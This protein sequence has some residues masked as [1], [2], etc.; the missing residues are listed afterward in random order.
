MLTNWLNFLCSFI[1]D[2]S[3]TASLVI[4]SLID[5]VFSMIKDG[6]FQISI[7]NVSTVI[8]IRFMVSTNCQVLEKSV[9]VFL[10]LIFHQGFYQSENVQRQLNSTNYKIYHLR[11]RSCIKF[12]A[13]KTVSGALLSSKQSDDHLTVLP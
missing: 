4:V 9:K 11:I 7:V 2:L 1:T 10:K 13:L 3:S 8:A 6:R 5:T 12:I